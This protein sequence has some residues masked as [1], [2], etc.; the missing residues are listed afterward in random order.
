MQ[1]IITLNFNNRNTYTTLKTPYELLILASLIIKETGKL[2][3]MYLVSTVFNNRLRIGMKLQN[4][5]AVFYGLKYKSKI[6]RQDFKINTPYNTYIHTGLPPTPICIPSLN[7]IKSAAQPL[8]KE[9][10][11]YFIAITSVSCIKLLS[12]NLIQ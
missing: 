2:D 6:V 11:Y 4:D 3:D 10:I 12:T 7:A 1:Q 5:P 8:N 9:N